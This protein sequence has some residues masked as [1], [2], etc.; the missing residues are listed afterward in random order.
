M[1]PPPGLALVKFP[2]GFNPD[3]TYQLRERE[4]TTLEEMKKGAISAEANL[5]EKRA[6]MRSEKKVTYRD[7]TFPSTS[8]SDSKIENLVRA[9]EIMM[10]RISISDR[11]PPSDIQP[12]PQ[13]KNWN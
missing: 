1:K 11:T 5:A 6:R 8:S 2:E 9:M 10:E 7:E 4:P 3:M 12:N 13:N